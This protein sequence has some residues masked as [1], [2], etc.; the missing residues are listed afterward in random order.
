VRKLKT[1][2]RDGT[3]HLVRLPPEFMQRLAALIDPAGTAY[4]N[5]RFAAFNLIGQMPGLGRSAT[6]R[7]AISPPHS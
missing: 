4:A 2:L 5:D 1:P 6:A 3:T 7:S